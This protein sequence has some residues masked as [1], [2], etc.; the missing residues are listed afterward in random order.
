MR[1]EYKFYQDPPQYLPTIYSTC[2]EHFFIKS[3]LKELDILDIQNLSD[4]KIKQ[5]LYKMLYL[6]MDRKSL[7]DGIW[8]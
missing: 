4:S 8:N 7:F 5:N 2:L 1:L 6:I 3:I